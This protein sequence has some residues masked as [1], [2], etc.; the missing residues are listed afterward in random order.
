[1]QRKEDKYEGHLASRPVCPF[2]CVFRT[3]CVRPQLA[4]FSIIVS[5]SIPFCCKHETLIN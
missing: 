5:L 4:N 3:F 1:M 2:T